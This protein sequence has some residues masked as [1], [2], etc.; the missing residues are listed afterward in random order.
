VVLVETHSRAEPTAQELV[1]IEAE[2]DGL[3]A[4][5]AMSRVALIDLAAGVI[6]RRGDHG[7]PLEMLDECYA[8]TAQGLSES[9][10]RA[11]TAP[12]TALDKVAAFLVAALETRR[13]RGTFLSFRR[14]GDLPTPLQRRLHEHDTAVRTRLKRIVGRGRRDGSLALRNLDTA[15]EL[16]LSSLQA[17]A[18]VVD[19]PEQRMWDSELTELLLAGLSE[20]HPPELERH[21]GAG[22]VQGGCLCGSVRFEIEAPFELL[23]HCRCSACRTHQGAATAP[24]L[25]V[26]LAGF[27]WLSGEEQVTL[28][29]SADRGRRSFCG[30][31]GS[32][33]PLVE[34]ESG[35]VYCPRSAQAPPFA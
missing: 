33:A 23:S 25:T 12:G 8:R 3:H 2:G 22:T 13:A 6:A 1:A 32:V 21:T 29:Q 15:V 31:C 11:E 17:P 35:V 28:Y 34:I 14:G 19:G 20:P 7:F 30:K 16:L 26:P 27:R 4:L 9:L 10:L 24:F 5:P 18:V